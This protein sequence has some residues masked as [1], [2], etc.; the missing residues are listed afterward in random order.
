MENVKQFQKL[1]QIYDHS[2]NSYYFDQENIKVFSK[3][4]ERL[5]EM[6]IIVSKKF[7]NLST[8]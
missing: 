3:N 7:L 2:G 8:Y 5:T 1:S 6:R 4:Q